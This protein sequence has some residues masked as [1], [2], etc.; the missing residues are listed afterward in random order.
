MMADGVKGGI[1][2]KKKGRETA[3][4]SEALAI[5][6]QPLVGRCDRLAGGLLPS[7]SL[8]ERSGSTRRDSSY[9]DS[10]F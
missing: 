8:T 7:V 2:L 5:W 1:I 9:P 3:V 6:C 4:Q 10:R